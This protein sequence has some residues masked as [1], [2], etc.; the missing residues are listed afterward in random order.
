MRDMMRNDKRN[1]EKQLTVEQ[2]LKGKLQTILKVYTEMEEKVSYCLDPSQG[3]LMSYQRVM[4][5]VKPELKQLLE[6]VLQA[7]LLPA[8]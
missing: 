6:E 8:V 7:C 2:E 1:L 5:M 4:E 3:E